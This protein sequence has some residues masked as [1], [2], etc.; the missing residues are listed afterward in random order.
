M[1]AQASR[2]EP[3]ALSV[4]VVPAPPP[5]PAA[6]GEEELFRELY[7]HVMPIAI[8]HARQLLTRDEA[9]DAVCDAMATLWEDRKKLTLEQRTP[10]YF[11]AAAHHEVLKRFKKNKRLVSLD[12]A[13][14]ELARLAI[15]E[16]DSPTSS[17]I[18]KEVEVLDRAIAALTDRRREVFL[19][20][21][22]LGYTYKEVGE[23]LSISEGT[24][25]SHMLKAGEAIRAAFER[26]GL[27]LT[28]G[29]PARL[30]AGPKGQTDV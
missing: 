2:T 5:L 15:H 9:R 18:Q 8:G 27:R 21:R 1:P 24:I 16:I 14:A 11:M 3:E 12:D 19:L 20:I 4:G 6:P 26:A 23:L 17:P 30:A 22:E 28:A 13:E 10:A 29:R 7:E 25:N